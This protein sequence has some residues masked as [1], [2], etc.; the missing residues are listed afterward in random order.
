LKSLRA[1]LISL[2]PEYGDIPANLSKVE[3]CVRDL[4]ARGVELVCFPEMSLTG[5][6][7]TA[8]IISLAQPS[9]SFAIKQIIAIASVYGVAVVV[10][11]P[12]KDLDQER[13]YISQVF[14]A[15][16]GTSA[17]YHK[18]HL[19]KSEQEVFSPGNELGL[20]SWGSITF[21]LQLC[22]DTHFPELSLAQASHGAQVLLMSFASPMDTPETLRARWLRFLPARAYDSGCFVL[23]CNQA[24]ASPDGKQ[25]ASVAL[26]INPDGESIA[27]RC[28][29]V[30]GELVVDLDLSQVQAARTRRRF[31]EQR[32]PELYQFKDP[33]S[34]TT[35]GSK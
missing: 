13:L 33:G 35:Q 17:I 26:A 18:A 10:G 24:G 2:A 11:L 30:P 31:I 9:G 20:V 19:R 21:G 6:S 14:C 12:M 7:R 27:E 3:G 29:A 34:I 32:R 23:V 5:Y 22:L 15:P 8:E 1:A 16:D 28:S 4:S 25:F